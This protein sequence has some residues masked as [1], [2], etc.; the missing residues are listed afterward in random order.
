MSK[1]EIN[2]KT[3]IILDKAQAEK[4]LKNSIS[5]EKLSPLIEEIANNTE[6]LL[7][8]TK[9]QK[10]VIQSI[11]AP[12]ATKAEFFLFIYTAERFGLDILKREIWCVKYK[13]Y[14][15]QIFVGRDGLMTLAHRSGVFKGIETTLEKIDE[16]LMYY[17]RKGELSAQRKEFSY[18][19][20]TKVWRT[21][22]EKPF[23]KTVYES[24][25]NTGI[26]Q[27]KIRPR[28]ML[29]KV[30]DAQCL[31]KAFNISGIYTPEEVQAQKEPLNV[32]M[33]KRSEVNKHLFEMK[34]KKEFDLYKMDFELK[35]GEN[36]RFLL[37]GKRNNNSETWAD[38]FETHRKRVS[39]ENPFN[40]NEMPEELNEELEEGLNNAIG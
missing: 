25:Y 35:H 17:N 22:F 21:D 6:S 5:R 26:E 4:D 39:G 7:T 37:S 14:P 23:V 15:A 3:K 38:V 10:T 9:D 11:Y 27:W 19:V 13:T 16:P 36:V 34:T 8:Y 30:A 20:T 40:A 18:K 24:E 29:E 31:R 28:T 12:T 2:Q 1:P 33:P 32:N